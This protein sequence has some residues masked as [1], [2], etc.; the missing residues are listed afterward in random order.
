M[1]TVRGL[2]LLA[3]IPDGHRR[4]GPPQLVVRREYSVIPMPVPPRRRDEI[5]EPVEKLQRRE[6]DD[7]VGPWPGGRSRAT[8]VA[9]VAAL[10][11]GST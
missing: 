11:L 6:F 3:N 10:R 4:D 5:G 2:P 9:Q 1:P 7:A 8:R